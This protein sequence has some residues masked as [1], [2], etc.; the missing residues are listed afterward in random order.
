MDA[1]LLGVI[2]GFVIGVGIRKYAP[3]LAT[4]ARTYPGETPGSHSHVRRGE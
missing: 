3:M 4:D 1:F 2:V